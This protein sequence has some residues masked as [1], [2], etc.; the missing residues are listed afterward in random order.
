M[1]HAV[2]HQFL[3]TANNINIFICIVVT[4]ISGVEPVVLNGFS[5]LLIPKQD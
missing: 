4:L 2:F 1:D 5:G 3:K